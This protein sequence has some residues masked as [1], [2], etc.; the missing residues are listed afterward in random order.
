MSTAAAIEAL[1]AQ[2][3]PLDGS[4]RSD[5]DTRLSLAQ[6]A[7]GLISKL[8][9]AVLR[10]GSVQDVVRAVQQA[11]KDAGLDVADRIALTLAGDAAAVVAIEAH[12]DL[13]AS[14]TLATSLSARE[15]ENGATPVGDASAVTIELERA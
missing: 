9:G 15:A 11:R 14:E 5:M 13:I 8:P 10:P 6:D 12:A 7:G 1:L 4:I 3:S 2:L